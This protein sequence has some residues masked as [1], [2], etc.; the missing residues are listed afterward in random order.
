V[1]AATARRLAD[2]GADTRLVLLNDGEVVGVGRERRQ[3]P[4]W[5]RDPSWRCTTAVPSPA[6]RS[7]RWCATSTSRPGRRRRPD[8]CRQPRAGV[9]HRQPPQGDRRLD[10]HA[11]GGRHAYL[12]P[13]PHRD[14]H[15]DPSGD[16]AH[17]PRP[18]PVTAGTTP[19]PDAAPRSTSTPSPA[20]PPW[21]T[22]PQRPTGRRRSAP[23]GR[24]PARGR[25]RPAVLNHHTSRPPLP[26]TRAPDR[27]RGSRSA[28][29]ARRRGRA[30][31][32]A[33]QPSRGHPRAR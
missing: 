4:G 3:P 14:Q 11:A 5:L 28:V 15:D 12:D 16:L 31:R 24:G 22:R 1:D 7:R 8:R 21:P 20:T 6:V 32:L 2:A 26:A 29:V 19:A 30:R 13:P 25:H 18:P 23:A 9:C 27:C 33:R 17:R 10:R